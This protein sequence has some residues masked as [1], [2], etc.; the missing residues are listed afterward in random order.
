M[1]NSVQF[2]LA[3]G[4]VLVVAA[5]AVF[6]LISSYEEGSSRTISLVLRRY[7]R[8]WQFTPSDIGSFSWVQL[9][10]ASVLSLFLEMLMIRWVT[11]EVAVF[12]YFKNVVLIGCF[13]GFGLGYSFCRR[14]VNLL[15]LGLPICLLVVLIKVPWPAL[16]S[17][18]DQIPYLI[19]EASDLDFLGSYVAS[20]SVLGT[21]GA[22]VLIAL[23]FALVAFVFV[24]LGQIVGWSLE[25]APDGVLAYTVNVL[26]SLAGIVLYSLLCFRNQ[27]P[28]VWFALSGIMLVLLVWRVPRWRWVSAGIFLFCVAI[29]GLQPPKP[30]VELWSPY[31]KITIEPKPADHP[32]AY[33]LQTNGAWYQQMIDLSPE[34]RLC[35]PGV[36]SSCSRGSKCVQHSIPI[37][38][39]TR[40]GFGSRGRDGK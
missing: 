14:K 19:G 23:L 33:E 7:S 34:F 32:I 22:I 16:R 12:A 18:M 11:S 29:V 10:L 21:L 6:L 35:S 4:F 39:P 15:A 26:A 1:T 30:A 8:R 40:V 24:P 25:T 13:L 27:P 2:P 17:V 20:T 38:S 5:S 31:Q 37:L 9:T 36:V 3:F 28:V